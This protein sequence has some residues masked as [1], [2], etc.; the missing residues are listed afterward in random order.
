MRADFEGNAAEAD[1]RRELAAAA[2]GLRTEEEL[3]RVR[4]SIASR[5]AELE[6]AL[7]DAGGRQAY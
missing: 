7:A 4:D 3:Q 2:L 1:R 6:A 5:T